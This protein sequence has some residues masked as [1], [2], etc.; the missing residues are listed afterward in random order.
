MELISYLPAQ[1]S[2]GELKAL[3]TGIKSVEWGRFGM[4]GAVDP[5]W[6]RIW[7]VGG[8]FLALKSFPVALLKSLPS[9][10]IPLWNQSIPWPLL[11][12]FLLSQGCSCSAPVRIHIL[13]PGHKSWL[14]TQSFL[15]SPCPEPALVR[16]WHLIKNLPS[17]GALR[18]EK[19]KL[20]QLCSSSCSG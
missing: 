19:W 18:L 16:G 9:F 4:V 1:N 15:T 7:G 6:D 3:F 13:G 10:P 2:L 17:Q 8:S 20:N 11:P 14:S 12:D 5:L